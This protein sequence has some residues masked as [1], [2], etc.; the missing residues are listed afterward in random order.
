MLPMHKN[1]VAPFPLVVIKIEHPNEVR[2][3]ESGQEL[4]L[5]LETL[6]EELRVPVL[7]DVGLQPVTD[8]E[9]D[10][11]DLVDRPM[12]PAPSGRTMR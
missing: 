9:L 5:S 7:E 2:V 4:A 1:L 11:L 3:F 6:A 8:G 10:V 12:P